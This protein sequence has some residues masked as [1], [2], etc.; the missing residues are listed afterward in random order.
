MS[1]PI[2]KDFKTLS[3]YYQAMAYYCAEMAELVTSKKAGEYYSLAEEYQQLA[4]DL[5]GE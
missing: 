5:I 4:D 3:D 1:K 2:K